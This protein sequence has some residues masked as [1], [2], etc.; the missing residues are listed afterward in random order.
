[1]LNHL[2]YH[3]VH[4]DGVVCSERTF[5]SQD[6][7]QAV[8]ERF[9]QHSWWLE[10]TLFHSGFCLAGLSAAVHFDLNKLGK[11]PS[12]WLASFP[13]LPRFSSSVCVQ[14]NTRKRKSTKNGEGL[15]SFIT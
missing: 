11:V 5:I 15:V 9:H 14:Y 7:F 4:F 10:P 2:V 6:T 3:H 13:G 8:A 12:F 1:M